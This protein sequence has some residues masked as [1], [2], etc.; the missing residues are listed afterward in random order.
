MSNSFPATLAA[1]T[2][3]ALPLAIRTSD[4]EFHL[5]MKNPVATG[6]PLYDGVYTVA[7]PT[8]NLASATDRP[9]GKYNW[10]ATVLID[11]TPASDFDK[12]QDAVDATACDAAW[13]TDVVS[14]A[15]L[16]TDMCTEWW[17]IGEQGISCVVMEGRL[18]RPLK[19]VA[20]D[21]TR[22]CDFNIDYVK[23]EVKIKTGIPVPTTPAAYQFTQTVDFNNFFPSSG[24]LSGL[25]S[26]GALV[27]AGVIA[28]AF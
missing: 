13:T 25:T 26:A 8:I 16:A 3:A 18:I 5:Q 17:N 28:V 2:A 6:K 1:E 27:L 20:N 19:A 11:T 7:K 15:A 12:T 22:E 9:V 24:A 23:H 10:D 14:L 4:V 21:I